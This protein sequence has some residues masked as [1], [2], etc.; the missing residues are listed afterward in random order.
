MHGIGDE[1]ADIGESE[2]RQYDLLDRRSGLADRI[3]R[4]PKRVRGH[5]LVVRIGA[6]EQQVP[7][8]RVRDEMLE[9]V[10][11]CRIEPLQIIEEQRERVLRPGKRAEKPPEHQL[12]A[13]LR[14][15]WWKIG[16]GWLLSDDE[17]QFWNQ[18]D[19]KASVRTQRLTKGL[20]PAS[21]LGFA[22]AEKWMDKAPKGLRQGGVRDVALV[23]VDFS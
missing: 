20:A 18:I 1:L 14:V 19:D 23:L 7:H 15:L 5:D 11:R 12:E 6:D 17:L 9:Q 13:V 3:Q 21:E 16:N 2:R 8:F 4:P 22:L 10:E